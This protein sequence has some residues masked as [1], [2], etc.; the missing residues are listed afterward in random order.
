MVTVRLAILVVFLI[1]VSAMAQQRT[2]FYGDPLPDGAVAR[3]GTVKFRL[4]RVESV[5]FRSTG[6]LVAFTE[7]LELHVWPADGS[8]KATVTSLSDGKTYGS[9]LALAPN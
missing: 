4:P 8:P 7:K 9:Y 3:L 1:P 6:E 2:D 5:G